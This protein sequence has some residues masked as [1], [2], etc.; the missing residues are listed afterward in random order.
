MDE[1]CA[2]IDTGH[3]PIYRGLVVNQDDKLRRDIILSLICHFIVDVSQI[4]KTY[5]IDF[6]NYFARE[7]EVLSQME[8]DAL[9]E[10]NSKIIKIYPLGKLLIR[11]IC[12]V[13]DRYLPRHQQQRFSK[14]I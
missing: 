4:E 2:L 8:G 14:V 1:Y 9:L 7:L 6:D 12:M 13:F 11:N 5:S 10:I 3:L